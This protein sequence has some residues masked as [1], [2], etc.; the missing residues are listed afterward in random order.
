MPSGRALDAIRDAN[1]L[2]ELAGLLGHRVDGI[3]FGNSLCRRFVAS[4]PMKR[5]QKVSENA[6]ALS[7]RQALAG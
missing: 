2:P 7:P 3:D 6:L 4:L 5:T 1:N